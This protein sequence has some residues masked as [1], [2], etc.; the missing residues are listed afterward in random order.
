MPAT[1]S[2]DPHS[3]FLWAVIAAFL[4]A[5]FVKGVVGL[6]QWPPR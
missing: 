1:L 5:G 3:A 6:G 4:L 2:F